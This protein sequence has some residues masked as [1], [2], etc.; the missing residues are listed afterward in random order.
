[1]A[2]VH[3]VLFITATDGEQIAK[4]FEEAQHLPGI[5]QA[6]VLTRSADG[7]VE[8]GDSYVHLAGA[9]TVPTGA[10]GALV[11]LVAGPM[12]SFL[13]MAAGAWVGSAL[14]GHNIQEA[15]AGLIFLGAGVPDASS[16]L[17]VELK[18]ED[19]APA[20]E[21]AARHGATLVRRPA[22]EVT[23]QV[24]AAE[25]AAE[26]SLHGEVEQAGSEDDDD[27]DADL[28]DGHGGSATGSGR[29]A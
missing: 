27:D 28:G 29:T 25:K 24:Q 16:Q 17:I 11:G 7:I 21:L 8:M 18:E 13:G 10:I 23:E 2:A 20:D 12:G 26:D 14:E 5:R 22:E 6:A 3:S 4:A 19:P 15:G 9:P 1:M